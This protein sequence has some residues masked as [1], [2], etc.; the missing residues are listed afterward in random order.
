MKNISP[1]PPPSIA[2]TVDLDRDVVIPVLEPV[3]SSISLSEASQLAHDL[4]SK[5][6]SMI[7]DA[8]YYFPGT[9]TQ[10]GFYPTARQIIVEGCPQDRS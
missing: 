1:I 10:I 2:A 9:D 6:V 5:E 4:I 8:R 7:L 3:L